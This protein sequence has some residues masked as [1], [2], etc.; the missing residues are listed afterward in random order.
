[1]YAE[2][3]FLATKLMILDMLIALDKREYLE[4]I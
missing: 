2:W 1:M 4:I 3:K